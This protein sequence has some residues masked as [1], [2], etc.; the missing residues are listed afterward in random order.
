V[1]RPYLIG[2]A[3]I[4]SAKISKLEESILIAIDALANDWSDVIFNTSQAQTLANEHHADLTP[5][6][7]NSSSKP[8]IVGPVIGGVV[9]GVA[10]LM[11]VGVVVFILYKR[12]KDKTQLSR[13]VDIDGD[14]NMAPRGTMGLAALMPHMPHSHSPSDSSSY[15]YL[16]STPAM[17]EVGP[18]YAS[19]AGVSS[20]AR[21]PTL[22]TGSM[23]SRPEGIPMV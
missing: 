16:M 23:T 14:E 7:S 5:G 22:Y 20:V 10:A 4:V 8:S 12:K 18:R 11:I 2:P 13:P 17:Q 19:P 6:T 1:T 21:T 15:S 3:R 9:G